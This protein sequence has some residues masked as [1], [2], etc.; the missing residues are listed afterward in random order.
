MSNRCSRAWWTL[1]LE[2][3]VAVRVAAKNTVG[4]IP[5]YVRDT[6]GGALPGVDV[7]ILFPDIGVERRT[8]TNAAGS[9][10]LAGL[11]TGRANLTAELS[12]FQ[13]FVR[14]DLK[15]E[16]NARMRLDVT[17]A[18][19]AVGEVMEVKG[20]EP[21]VSSSPDVAHLITGE[22]THDV[23]VDGPH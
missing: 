5:G 19:G 8:Q 20:K 4:K 23:S 13:R 17:L 7:R 2:L 10:L 18:V 14:T 11:P 21:L 6:A 16:L 12:G 15:V 9:F 3:T 1:L 22:Q